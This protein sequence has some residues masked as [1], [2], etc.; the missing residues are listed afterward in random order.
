[1]NFAFDLTSNPQGSTP[2]RTDRA[3]VP[4]MPVFDNDMESNQ[5]QDVNFG[6]GDSFSTVPE[7]EY[8]VQPSHFQDDGF[9][10]GNTAAGSDMSVGPRFNASDLPTVRGFRARWRAQ[11]QARCDEMSNIGD[12]GAES[13]P[14]SQSDVFTNL[15]T[16]DAKRQ[17]TDISSAKDAHD[18]KQDFQPAQLQNIARIANF[19]AM[20]RVRAHDI[21]MPWEKGPL[22][23][24]FGGPMPNVPSVKSLIPPT[25]GLVDTLAPAVLT[26]QDTPVQVGPISK[27]AVKRIAAAKCVVPEDEMLARCLN[28]I[29]NLLLLDLQG[30]E[31]GLTLCNLAG[32]LDESVDVLQVLKDCFAKKATATILKRTSALWT[33]AGWMLENEQ[34]TVW[35]ITES[36]LY[37]YMCY[38]RDNQAAPTKA[39]HLVEALNFFDST[40][41]FKKTVC[42]TILSPR[43]QGAAHAMY[44]EKRKLKVPQLTVAAVK[45]LEI[46]CTSKTNLLRSAISGALLF[47]IFAAARWSDFARLENLWTDRCG[48]LV[49]VEAET[50][51]HKTSKSKEAKTRLLPFTALGR[52]FLDDS[53]GECFVS[54]L[55][56]IKVHTGLSFLPSWN[57]R[58][59]T[60]S[61]SPMTTA[62]AS[63]FLKEMLE[64]I[65]GPEAVAQFSAH[66]C[67]PTILTW[68]G[69][70][71]ILTR[72]E[73][74]MMGHHI[75][76]TTKSATTYNRDSQLL[77]QA[78]VSKVLDRI[79]HGQMDPDATRASRLNRLTN[80]DQA[81]NGDETSV[82]SDVEDTEVASIHSKVHLVDRPSVPL[83]GPDEY[84][85][86]AHKLT[87][88]IHV[89]QEE[90]TGRLACGRQKTVNMKPVEP[91]W[92][93]DATA[94]FCI[95]CNA[96]VKH[97]DAQT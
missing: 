82:E 23:P 26:K 46:I 3:S 13:V 19:E 73:R 31:V 83:G 15:E 39:S 84:T 56:Q 81:D 66:S 40:L 2:G 28:Q 33:L 67:K 10:E 87:G 77:L 88:T 30:T 25:V 79:I 38:L 95:Q 97:H 63:L 64:P 29:K 4:A 91:S 69:M 51:R 43:V 85:F 86:V 11:S 94:P 44:L 21:K 57:D 62:E 89:L 76:P 78:K 50:S 5:F 17:R 61:V 80:T 93:D 47:C 24:I 90:E 65:L 12:D 49:L 71:D 6:D 32:G 9:V 54:A 42:R 60:W 34:T 70:T 37:S 8:H 14:G 59:G 58:S 55:N 45:A 53:W 48:D 16:P 96:V 18:D 68:C 22:A 36:Q 72:E 7:F 20:Q 52:F 27:F 92:I 41:R 35:D 74:T 75:E 1:M